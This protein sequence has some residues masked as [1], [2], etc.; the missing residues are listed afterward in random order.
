MAMS[1]LSQ[2]KRTEI[3]EGGTIGV[4]FEPAEGSD[5]FAVMLG[6][7]YGGIPEGP[8]RKLAESGVCT[9]A[10]GYFGAPGLPSE[11][12]EIPLES[13][14]K[15]IAWFRESRAGDRAVGLLG[16]SKGAELAL[17]LAA[18]MPEAIGPA[19]AVAPSHAVWFGLKAPGPD[20]DRRSPTSSWSLQGAPVAF[21]PCPPTFNPVF[22][23]MGLR[24]D[25]FFDLAGYGGEVADAARIRIEEAAGPILL[26]SGDD[27]HQW[28]AAQMAAE[29]ERRMNDHGRGDDIT[30]VVYPDA[31]HVFLMR[32]FIPP[33]MLGIG[34]MYDFG[35]TPE[36]DTVAGEDAWRR[37]REFLTASS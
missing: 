37:I 7:S 16:F 8:A 12:V 24:T 30:N 14:E 23:E 31:G 33:A 6:G 22:N 26:L 32:E 19:I 10:L 17:V 21:L 35:G 11:L 13:P 2:V 34:G 28:P 1:A 9:L 27:D 29:I 18:R 25:V 5:H 4:V 3:R 36:A 20:G 15:G